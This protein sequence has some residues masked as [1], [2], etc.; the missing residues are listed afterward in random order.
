MAIEHNINII[1][2][3]SDNILV[4]D[5][6]QRIAYGQA[7]EIQNNQKVIDA[8]LGTVDVAWC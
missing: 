7:R 6:G 4:L 8:Y 3:I 1:M 2:E 5:Q